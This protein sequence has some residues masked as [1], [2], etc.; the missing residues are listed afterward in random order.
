MDAMTYLIT[1]L[2]ITILTKY[3]L[4]KEISLPNYLMND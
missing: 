2:T 1:R 4:N 3:L